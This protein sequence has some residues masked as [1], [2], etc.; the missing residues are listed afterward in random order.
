[1]LINININYLD[2]QPT[3]FFKIESLG[4]A[5]ED[6][7]LIFSPFAQIDDHFIAWFTD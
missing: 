4:L 5:A 2:Q 3:V 7:L 1:M 6:E